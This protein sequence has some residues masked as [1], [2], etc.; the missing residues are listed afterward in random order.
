MNNEQLQNEIE[1]ILNTS[2][3]GVLS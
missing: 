3:I 2:K 1:N